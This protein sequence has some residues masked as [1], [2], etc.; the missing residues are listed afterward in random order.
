MHKLQHLAQAHLAAQ[1]GKVDSRH[2]PTP[3][4]KAEQRRETMEERL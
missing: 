2:R 3:L 4:Q 1:F